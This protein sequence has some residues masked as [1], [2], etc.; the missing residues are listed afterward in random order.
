MMLWC[1]G[2]LNESG[3]RTPCENDETRESLGQESNIQLLAEYAVVL[4]AVLIDACPD[5]AVNK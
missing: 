3:C 4:V 1:K 5:A 2:S